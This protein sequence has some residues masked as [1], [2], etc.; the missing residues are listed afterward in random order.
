MNLQ[1]ALHEGIAILKQH[2]CVNTYPEQE[3]VALLV[4][5]LK[6]NK[7]TLIINPNQPISS[8][9]FKS[10]LAKINRRKNHEPLDYILKSSIF[11]NRQFMV[12][13]HVLIPRAATEV[14]VKKIIND[15]KHQ[16]NLNIIEIGTGSGAIAITLAHELAATITAV[17]VSN[18]AL[19]MA[20]KNWKLHQ[21]KKSEI[22]FVKSDLLNKIRY[23][24]NTIIVANLPYLSKRDI[25]AS[26]KDV[27]N[28]EPK[29]ALD[30]F[31]KDGFALYRKLI[32]NVLTRKIPCTLYFEF[33]P[34]QY[35]IL[36]AIIKQNNQIIHPIINDANIIIGAK[37]KVIF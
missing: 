29:L 36:E 8:A 30:G 28:F 19:N 26:T 1:T 6:I 18:S 2:Q 17:D 35:K 21:N 10:F 20:R 15:L 32:T 11:F 14:L 9:H 4:N 13:K 7:E 37:I 34:E 23:A 3:A 22:K 27:R 31:G 5:M 16:P 24:E 12:N 33:L 25:A